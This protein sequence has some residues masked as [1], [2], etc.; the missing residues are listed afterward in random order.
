MRFI[1]RY[2][3]I[4]GG[5]LAGVSFAAVAHFNLDTV[6]LYYSIIILIIV[7]IGILRIVKQDIDK[8][9]HTERK[10]TVV[11]SIVDGQKP[12]KAL[13]IA[14]EPTQEGEKIGKKIIEMWGGLKPTMDKIKTFFSKFK[15]YI[16]TVALAVLTVIEMWGGYLD[17]LCG[18]VLTVGGVKVIPLVTL[19][20]TAV[21]GIVS[22]GF[23]KEDREKIKA[24][25]SKTNTNEL[26][27]AEIKKS[28]KEKT[29]QLSTLNKT[30]STQT[31]ELVDLEAELAQATD[32]LHAKREMVSMTPRL[33]TEQDVQTAAS[34]VSDCNTRIERKREEIRRTNAAID[35]LNVAL[36]ALRSQL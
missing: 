23:T 35:E 32:T 36:G 12:I 17:T 7:C 14:T 29:A 1:R 21:V 9:R 11:D 25:L 31:R 15:G 6:Q 20:C 4:I 5:I 16:L 28:I 24:L 10:H 22:N 30:L 8:R 34:A 13:R 26:I 33:A 19:A 3:D 27:R 18:G 2:W